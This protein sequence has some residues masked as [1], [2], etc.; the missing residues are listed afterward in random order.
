MPC[1]DLYE[2]SKYKERANSKNSA[3]T[4]YSITLFCCRYWKALVT[5]KPFGS[6]E[7]R[8]NCFTKL[9]ALRD[10]YNVHFITAL[11]EDHYCLLYPR[12]R[13]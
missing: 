9:K 8:S 2:E 3:N 4:H 11:F 13:V 6:L 1:S 7:I 5:E 10:N 12:G